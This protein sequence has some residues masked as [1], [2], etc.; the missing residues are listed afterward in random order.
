MRAE[1]IHYLEADAAKCAK[2]TDMFAAG[3]VVAS[4]S[5]VQHCTV[6]CVVW[7]GNRWKLK[8]ERWSLAVATARERSRRETGKARRDS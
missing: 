8:E 4:A 1:A 3:P 5:T 6:L 7:C 2:I